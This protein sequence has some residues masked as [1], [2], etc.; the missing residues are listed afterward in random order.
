LLFIHQKPLRRNNA[1]QKQAK[2]LLDEYL[3]DQYK[4]KRTPKTQCLKSLGHIKTRSGE[5][6]Y[7]FRHKVKNITDHTR[8]IDDTKAEDSAFV[9]IARAYRAGHDCHFS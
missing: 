8:R 1:T 2:A 4:L 7:H 9:R 6:I 3:Q 5:L